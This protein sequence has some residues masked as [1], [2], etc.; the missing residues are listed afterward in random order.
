[1]SRR[2]LWSRGNS[3][4]NLRVARS[5]FAKLG[6]VVAMILIGLSLVLLS[7]AFWALGDLTGYDAAR[8]ECACHK[9]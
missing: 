8:R 6:K 5:N 9:G 1:M 3:K 4:L 2:G 7:A